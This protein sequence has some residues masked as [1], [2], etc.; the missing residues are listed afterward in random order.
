MKVGSLNIRG[1]G[2]M[3]KKKKIR[4]LILEERLDF[5][6]I[7]E[8]KVEQMES[9]LCEQSWGDVNCGWVYHPSIGN[10]KGV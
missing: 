2:A 3:I 9:Q 5:I 7:Q 6:A 10:A 8:T 1:L 4:S